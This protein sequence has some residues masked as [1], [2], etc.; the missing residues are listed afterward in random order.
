MRFPGLCIALIVAA[1]SQSA[2]HACRAAHG[3]GRTGPPAIPDDIWPN[4]EQPLLRTLPEFHAPSQIRYRLTLADDWKTHTPLAYAFAQGDRAMVRVLLECGAD[5]NETIIR[6]G[7]NSV[8]PMQAAIRRQEPEAVAFLLKVGAK[9]QL[10]HLTDVLGV[11]DPEVQVEMTRLILDSGVGTPGDALVN[12]YAQ[13]ASAEAFALL[14]KHGA[15]VNR[16]VGSFQM[17]PTL[18]SAISDTEK[19]RIA[20]QHGADPNQATFRSRETPLHACA[21]SGNASTVELLVK[22]GAVVTVRNRNGETPIEVALTQ[23]GFRSF[24]QKGD[25]SL[26]RALLRHGAE[27]SIAAEVATGNVEA[28]KRRKNNNEPVVGL[29]ALDTEKTWFGHNESRSDLIAMAASF[30]QPD[31]LKW[32]LENGVKESTARLPSRPSDRLDSPALVIAAFH[33]DVSSVETLLKH[34]ADPNEA[35]PRS[36]YVAAAFTPL[37]AVFAAASSNNRFVLAP[38]DKPVKLNAA[39]RTIIRR[40]VDYGADPDRK[41]GYGYT[42]REFAEKSLPDETLFDRKS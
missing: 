38:G 10:D 7:V 17:M 13:S 34:G 30:S 16:K 14:F 15:R 36:V 37:H 6:P 33:G 42:P 19:A 27:T 20:L 5:P 26:V 9:P 1:A 11:P 25:V 32:L 23:P 39:Q 3:T 40:L 4:D 21:R 41:N 22:S 2:D 24:S 12:D 35:S 8:S 31:S 18:V 28:L 29:P